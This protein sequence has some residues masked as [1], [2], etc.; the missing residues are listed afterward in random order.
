MGHW[1]HLHKTVRTLPQGEN[2]QWPV[3]LVAAW[4]EV[5]L[6]LHGSLLLEA[7]R[8][9]RPLWVKV[10]LTN[11]GT[12]AVAGAYNIFLLF[13]M[14]RSR[15][16][17]YNELSRYFYIHFYAQFSRTK[18]WFFSPTPFPPLLPSLFWLSAGSVSATNYVR[19]G[20]VTSTGTGTIPENDRVITPREPENQRTKPHY[21]TRSC[22]IY[23]YRSTVFSQRCG[24]YEGPFE[25]SVFLDPFDSSRLSWSSWISSCWSNPLKVER[26]AMH[27]KPSIEIYSFRKISLLTKHTGY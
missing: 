5:H 10:K 26:R 19:T 9:D 20:T 14:S 2:S 4:E 21:G 23:C 17:E 27:G 13:W 16:P 12:E 11:G 6:H 18:F 3:W 24:V 7:V 8:L 25:E 22:Y 1:L 15:G